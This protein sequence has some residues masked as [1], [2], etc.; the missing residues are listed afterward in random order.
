MKYGGINN[1]FANGIIALRVTRQDIIP[2]FLQGIQ[3]YT[4]KID[5]NDK[6]QK[7]YKNNG[8]KWRRV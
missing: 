4:R 5:K 7:N 8:R 3:K 1:L 2:H 6:N